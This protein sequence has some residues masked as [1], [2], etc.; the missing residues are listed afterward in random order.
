MLEQL[1]ARFP[2]APVRYW[3]DKSGREVD[4]V[5]ASRR[6]AVDAIECK[7]DPGA[8][9]CASLQIFRSHYPQGRNFLVTPAGDPG[10]DRRC[11]DLMVCVCTPSE[12]RP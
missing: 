6:D 11:G 10:Y 1:Q 9:D 3:R 2:D 8:F 12:L 4:F 7:W 5:L